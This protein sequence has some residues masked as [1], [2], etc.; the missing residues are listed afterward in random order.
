MDEAE[1]KAKVA[2][3]LGVDRALITDTTKAAD[4]Q[5]WDSM[6]TMSVLIMLDRDYGLKLPPNRTDQLG[7]IAGILGLLREARQTA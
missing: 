2:E 5:E 1:L 6:G 3:A 4:L 7:S